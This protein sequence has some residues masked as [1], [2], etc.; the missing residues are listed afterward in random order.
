MAVSLSPYAA[1]FEQFAAALEARI[2]AAI[3]PDAETVVRCRVQQQRL[4]V[5]AE[6]TEIATDEGSRDRHFKALAIATQTGLLATELPDALLSDSGQ[7]PVRLYLRKKGEAGPYAARRWSWQPVD[8]VAE[9]FD[10]REDI[11]PPDAPSPLDDAPTG[12]LVLVPS[13]LV[14]KELQGIEPPEPDAAAPVTNTSPPPRWQRYWQR[15]LTWPWPKIAALTASGLAAGI[16]AYGVTRPCLVGSCP[17]RQT[18]HEL[19]ETALTQLSTTPTV[20]D[21]ATAQGQLI[22]A[23]RLL[24]AVPPWSRHYDAIQSDLARYRSQLA[25]L[26][27]VMDAQDAAM[28]A[29]DKSQDPPHPVAHWVE[30]HLLWQRAIATLQRIPEDSPLAT[31]VQT[32]LGEY[33]ANHSTIGDRIDAETA[34]ETNLNEALQAGQLANARTETA[35]TLPAWQLAQQDWQMAVNALRRIPKGTLAYEEASPL[36]EN[37]QRQLV[38]TRTRVNQEKAGDRAYTAAVAEAQQAQAAQ[39]QGQ[40]TVAVRH[41]RRAVDDIQ[42]VPEGTGRYGEAQVLLNVY[43]GSLQRAGVNLRQAVA[44][45]TLTADLAQICPTGTARCT[46]TTINQQARI[47]L[48]APYDQGVLQ[49]ISPPS[50]Q[51]EGLTQPSAIVEQTHT[52]IQGI[53]QLGNRSQLE[54]ELYDSEG[55]FIAQ[56]KPAYG[57]FMKR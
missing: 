7:L 24:S 32:K 29:A 37:Y 55:Q 27:W 16:L 13:T 44:L 45:Q 41:W 17:R 38:T 49:S 5:L 3:A 15:G 34:A 6:E 23:I 9:L 50:S 20:A 8:A 21:V 48:L 25:D 10:T 28:A 22:D 18:A 36:Q 42:Q 12:S 47:T 51:G 35:V 4:L 14:P 56:Y 11:H 19:S 39:Q 2:Q 30:V 54:I 53:M 1:A 26:S 43:Q 52:L 31:L 57:G 40:W 33:E 46:Y